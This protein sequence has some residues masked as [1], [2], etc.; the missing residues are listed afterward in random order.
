MQVTEFV[1]VEG[2]SCKL[3]GEPKLYRTGEESLLSK[4]INKLPKAKRAPALKVFY[5]SGAVI[6]RPKPAKA[7]AEEVT[8]EDHIEEGD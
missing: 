3:P 5:D 6:E 8:E 1:I 2:K 7:E 4:A